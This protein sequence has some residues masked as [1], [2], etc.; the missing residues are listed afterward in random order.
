MLI[1]DNEDGST[2]VG[3]ACVSNRIK[4]DKMLVLGVWF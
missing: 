3:F 1:E 2:M 4:W